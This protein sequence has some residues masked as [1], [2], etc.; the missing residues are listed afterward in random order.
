[1]EVGHYY[2]V[3]R[4][5]GFFSFDS[6]RRHLQLQRRVAAFVPACFRR[7]SLCCCLV[8]VHFRRPCGLYYRSCPYAVLRLLSLSYIACCRKI[9]SAGTGRFRFDSVPVAHGRS[10]TSSRRF[11]H[12]VSWCL[13]DCVLVPTTSWVTHICQGHSVSL[14]IAQSSAVECRTSE[15]HGISTIRSKSICEII[16][17]PAISTN[18]YPRKLTH[19]QSWQQRCRPSAQRQ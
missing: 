12:D 18:S 1:M 15:R 2:F 19:G 10:L 17:C 14:V 16:S 4:P 11:A 3:T 6:S 9:E 7:S 8:P 13:H 5:V